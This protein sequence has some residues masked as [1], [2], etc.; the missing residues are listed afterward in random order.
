[1]NSIII[2]ERP[3]LELDLPSRTSPMTLLSDGK[4]F[5]SYV[6]WSFAKALKC[7][8]YTLGA[9]YSFLYEAKR[10]YDIINNYYQDKSKIISETE[11]MKKKVE[12]YLNKSQNLLIRYQK[13]SES[14]ST[15][16]KDITSSNINNID[17][18]KLKTQNKLKKDINGDFDVIIPNV[19]IN[20]FMEILEN[21][22]YSKNADKCI[23][24]D[25]NKINNLP[26]YFNLFIEVGISSFNSTY[27]HKT[28]QIHKYI[29]LLNFANNIIE[30]E[31]IRGIY[32]KDFQNRFSLNLNKNEHEIAD[33]SVFMLVS[34]NSYGEFTY[35]FIDNRGL[36][37]LS[38]NN[39]LQNIIPKT[40]KEIL[41]CAFVDFPK[42]MNGYQKDELIKV[43]NNQNM[44]M[45]QMKAQLKKNDK[46]QAQLKEMDVMK[47]KKMDEMV[48]QLKEMDKMKEQ[49]KEMD[50]M[51]EQ[52][53]EMD[54]M[55]KELDDLKKLTYNHSVEDK[56]YENTLNVHNNRNY[57][58]Q[59]NDYN[60]GNNYYFGH[61]NYNYD[62]NDYYFYNYNHS[63]GNNQYFN[64][65]YHY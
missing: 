17:N 25:E 21:N 4:R 10:L 32:I 60:Y 51:K 18:V 22:F 48:E 49:L 34:N 13:N 47:S 50:K 29:A 23:I 45:T 59:F 65:F 11:K 53:K 26:K 38:N 52:L 58:S 37:N 57:Y 44:E 27:Q 1:M 7:K 35:R 24:Y 14:S 2:N 30:D 56:N 36:L 62:D 9:K 3:G 39:E 43:I 15:T 5:E 40:S 64:N 28:Q 31:K 12:D 33:T 55:Q 19:E 20:S 41:L 6:G 16:E 61:N 42:I 63:F 54:K 8:K 46:I